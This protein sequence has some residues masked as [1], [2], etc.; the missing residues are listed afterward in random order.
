[1]VQAAE[2]LQQIFGAPDHR[3]DLGR[4]ALVIAQLQHPGLDIQH[5]IDKLGLFASEASSRLQGRY[6]PERVIEQL[7]HFLF[8]DLAFRGN[9]EDYYD[10]RNSFLSDVIDRRTGIPITLAVIYLE[11]SR[12][13][14]LPFYGVGLPGHFV[15]KYDDN[16]QAI[17]IDP[18]HGGRILQFEQCRELIARRGDPASLEPLDLRAVDNRYIIIRMLN[19]LRGIYLRTRQFREAVGILDMT[20]SLTPSSARDIKQRAWLHHELRQYGRACRDLEAYLSLGSPDDPEREGIQGWIREIY[21]KIASM[22]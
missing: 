22:N 11:V 14:G 10:P 7:N 19:N 18:F 13:L 17:L 12:R 5:Y 6:D 4:A 15:L 9:E 8:V 20:V 16:R 3:I 1:M 2:E 21:E